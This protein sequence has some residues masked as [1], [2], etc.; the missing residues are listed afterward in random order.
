MT[1]AAVPFRDTFWN[2]PP[3]AQVLLY[4]GQC[5]IRQGGEDPEVH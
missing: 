5:L 2:I 3:W 4:V 1:T